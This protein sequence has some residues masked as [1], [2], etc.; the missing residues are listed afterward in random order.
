[1]VNNTV[2]RRRKALPPKILVARPLT[3]EDLV[4]L[5]APRVSHRVAAFRESHHRLA[6]LVASGLRVEQVLEISGY[7]YQR[8]YTLR[9]DPAFQELVSQYKARVDNKL[10]EIVDETEATAVSNL[11][12]MERMVEE[13]LEQADAEGE[14]IPLKTL[15]S[16]ISDRMD[17]FGYSKKQV[18]LN[19]NAT[20]ASK[21]ERAIDKT[22][23]AKQIEGRVISHSVSETPRAV[24][25]PESL[26]PSV[27]HSRADRGAALRQARAAAR[28][29]PEGR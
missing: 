1:M 9:Q 20:L 3:R 6:R 14:L 8:L 5:N 7:S 22:R 29:L 15:S 24:A 16:L 2:T 17:R 26:P 18:N 28:A 19:F 11:R 12:R 21:L 4:H 13:H 27:D 25:A 23:E 10:A